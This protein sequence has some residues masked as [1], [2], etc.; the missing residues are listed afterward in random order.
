M[1]EAIDEAALGSSL[2]PLMGYAPGGS[3]V[4]YL[5]QNGSCVCNCIIAGIACSAEYGTALRGS[6][7]YTD[8]DLSASSPA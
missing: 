5:H 1:F 4:S 2:I 8:R 7:M 3:R 6:G